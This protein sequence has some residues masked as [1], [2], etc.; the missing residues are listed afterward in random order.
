MWGL[1]VAS[2]R[3]LAGWNPSRKSKRAGK[4]SQRAPRFFYNEETETIYRRSFDGVLLHCL[5]K[6][7]SKEVMEE[8]HSGLCGNHQPR[9]KLQN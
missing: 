9:P 7:E 3:I 4:Y 1:E 6:E 8:V 2:H 5:T